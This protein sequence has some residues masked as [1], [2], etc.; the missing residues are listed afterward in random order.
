MITQYN[1]ELLLKRGWTKLTPAIASSWVWVQP[2][3]RARFKL[4]DA[5]EYENAIDTAADIA[6]RGKQEDS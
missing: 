3:T 5:L 6:K 4:I 2:K 1:V